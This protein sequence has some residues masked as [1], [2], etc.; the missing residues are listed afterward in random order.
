MEEIV[1]TTCQETRPQEE[2]GAAWGQEAE[3]RTGA[4]GTEQCW[5]EVQ[6]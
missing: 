2:P 4:V 5:V 6:G 3:E 1:A